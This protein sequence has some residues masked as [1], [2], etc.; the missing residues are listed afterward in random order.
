M[1]R[2]KKRDNQEMK[3]QV[4]VGDVLPGHSNAHVKV[5]AAKAVRRHVSRH[6][7]RPNVRQQVSDHLMAE[8]AGDAQKV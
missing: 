3:R 5:R 2:L 6:R 1:S 7:E 4:I 8:G